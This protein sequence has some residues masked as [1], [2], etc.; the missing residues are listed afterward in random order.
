[1]ALQLSEPEEAMEAPLLVWLTRR[2]WIRNDTLVIRELPWH[3][4]RVDVA[5]LTKTG[6]STAYELKLRHTRRVLEQSSLNALSFDRS[7]IVTASRPSQEN[8]A[9]A[10]ALGLGILLMNLATGSVEL[11][12][13]PVRQ[14]IAPTVR[15]R[16]RSKIES[17][18][19]DV[20]VR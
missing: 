12:L 3:G 5:T 2:R 6:V 11:L 10:E 9:Q 4:R 13:S 15:L 16:L 19:G 14:D 8:L 1:M 18:A 20:Y 17:G 7:C